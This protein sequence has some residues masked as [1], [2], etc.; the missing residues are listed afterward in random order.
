MVGRFVPAGPILL[1][2][3]VLLS[4]PFPPLPAVLIKIV[5]PLVVS[6][7]VEEPRMEQ[8]V[9]VLPVASATKRIVDVPL[10]PAVEVLEI[11]KEFPPLFR[12][13]IV[14]LSAP[15]NWTR[16]APE[17]DPE[18]VRAAPPAGEIVTEV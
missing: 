17:I 5:P 7:V 10:V 8:F 6:P 1:F 12:P 2:E 16:A 15:F 18:I 9:I 11:V 3:N 4:F 13:L 14:T